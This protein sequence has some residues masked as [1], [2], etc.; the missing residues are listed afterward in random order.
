MANTFNPGDVVQLKS[1]GPRMT[2]E[3]YVERDKVYRC[4]WFDDKNQHQAVAFR[5]EVL[6]RID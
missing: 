3:G 2:V 5:E 1:C 6:R 4:T